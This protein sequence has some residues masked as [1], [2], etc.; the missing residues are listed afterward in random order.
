LLLFFKKEALLSGRCFFL[1]ESLRAVEPKNFHEF[2]LAG[3]SGN[4]ENQEFQTD[5]LP[6][7]PKIWFGWR[8][9]RHRR[10]TFLKIYMAYAWHDYCLMWS[11]NASPP[12]RSGL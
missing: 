10:Q 5:P 1:E 9:F 8:V 2:V 7:A 12:A 3:F 6:A 11:R 4:G